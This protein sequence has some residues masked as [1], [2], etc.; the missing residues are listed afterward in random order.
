MAT[1]VYPLNRHPEPEQHALSTARV[2]GAADHWFL[3]DHPHC[4]RARVAVSCLLQPQVGDT[5]LVSQAQSHTNGFV[6]A[7][8]ER[9]E[10]Q[11]G[12]LTLPGNNHIHLTAGGMTLQARQL[13]L[14]GQEQIDIASPAVNLTAVSS[15]VKVKHWQGWF[16]TV[17]S[18][19]VNVST[20]AK[21]LSSKVGRLMQRV[22]ESFRKTDG[23]DEV[24]AGRVRVQV[25][26][27]HQ[28]Q[29]QHIS[30]TA[31]G[32]V[33]IDGQKIDLG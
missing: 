25:E 15:T 22:A 32:F 19:A 4:V 28:T 24:R 11:H 5:V 3:L 29:A 10:A 21:T 23:L 9:P 18:Y 7:V 1:N 26:G 20:T 27:H 8:L 33:K 31:Q 30:S 13:H 17:E 14:Q 12:Q 16:D 2:T 6:L